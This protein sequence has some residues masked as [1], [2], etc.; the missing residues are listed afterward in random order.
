METKSLRQIKFIKSIINPTDAAE[1]FC[2]SFKSLRILKLDNSLPPLNEWLNAYSKVHT[3]LRRLKVIIY[4]DELS[5]IKKDSLFKF[6]KAQGKHFCLRI[7]IKGVETSNFKAAK[8]SI[9][10]LFN[11]HFKSFSLFNA[12]RKFVLVE[13]ESTVSDQDSF[14]SYYILRENGETEVPRVETPTIPSDFFDS[15]A[16]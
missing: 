2:N 6:F 10:Q 7:T 13:L 16:S 4:G 14:K 1:F 11:E 15:F 8:K 5:A 9:N 12:F 3:E